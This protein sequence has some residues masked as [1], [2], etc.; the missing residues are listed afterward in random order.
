[1]RR[2]FWVLCIVAHLCW[3]PLLSLDVRA[4]K[5][6]YEDGRPKGLEVAAG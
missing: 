2:R 4:R 1:M 5:G 3:A 6:E